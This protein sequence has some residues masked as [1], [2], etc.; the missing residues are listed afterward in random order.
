MDETGHLVSGTEQEIDCD[1]LAINYGFIANSELPAMCGVRMTFD[2]NLGG[3][4]PEVD[5][6]GRTSET[7]V[8][9]AGDA[10]GLR[11][12][13]VAR[14]EGDIVGATVAQDLSPRMLP[15]APV[16]GPSL[17]ERSRHLSFQTALRRSWKLPS[18]LWDLARVEAIVC[19]CEHVTGAE[20]EASVTD[21]YTSLNAIK[22]NT[23]GVDL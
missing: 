6:G 19:R 20:I 16:S 11:G 18:R 17:A 23:S 8:Y 12:A 7:G 22:R 1:L 15:G 21:G 3:W 2:E 4:L 9:V 5:A 10:A 13:F 14:A